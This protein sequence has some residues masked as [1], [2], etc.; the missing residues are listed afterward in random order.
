MATTKVI[1]DL[2]DLNQTG[3]TTALK[4]CVGTNA[5]QPAT[6][7]ISVQ[8]LVVGGGGGANGSGSGG[9]GAGG[10]S[11]G[12]IAVPNNTAL[13]IVVGQG[14]LG[15]LN[16]ASDGLPA[17]QGQD[18]GFYTIQGQGGGAGVHRGNGLPGGS[19]AGA[20]VAATTVYS[21]GNSVSGQGNNGGSSSA[22]WSA[23]GGGGS[24]AVGTNGIS[25]Q[26]GAGGAGSN[27]VALGIITQANGIT[28]SIGEV[29]GATLNFAGGGGGGGSDAVA[30]GNT[31]GGSG[32]LGGGGNGSGQCTN[33]PGGDA[34]LNTGGGGGGSAAATVDSAGGS[35]GSGVVILKYAN[36]VTETIAG[37]LVGGTTTSTIGVCNYPTTAT[38]LYQFENTPNATC[39]PNP[40]NGVSGAITQNLTYVAGVP[41]LGASEKAVDFNGTNSYWMSNT[42]IIDAQQNMSISLWVKFDVFIDTGYLWTSY[43]TGDMVLYAGADGII[44]GNVWNGGSQNVSSSA[45]ST[46]TWY[47]VVFTRSTSNGMVLYING[48]S[49]STNSNTTNPAVHG[50]PNYDTIGMYGHR[51]LNN[52]YRAEF[53]GQIDQ[54]RAFQSELTSSQVLMLYGEDT[55]ATKFTE[56]S[57]TVLVFKS[58]SGTINLTDTSLP[59]PKVGDLRTNTDQ[60]SNSSASA[61]EH[62]M[63]TGWRVFNN[64]SNSTAAICNYPTTALALYQFNDDVTDTCNNY[65]GT[66]Y[67]LNAYVGGKI[68]KA[69]SFNGSSSKVNITSPIG[70]ALSNANDDFSVSLWVNW[71]SITGTAGGFNGAIIGNSSANNYGS[72][73][74]Y[75]Y[76]NAAGISISVERYFN[77]TGYYS[78]GYLT[79]APFSGVINTWYNLV[80]TYVGSSKT[81]TT[82]V[83]G[84]ALPTYTLNT[85]AGSRTMSSLNSFGSYNGS[86]SGL[87]GYLDQLR[88]FPSVLTAA[89]VTQL[90]NES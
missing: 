83:N 37:S 36:T 13:N 48:A 79:A 20:G 55:G 50:T 16:N 1:N 28:A 68:G 81:V 42:S 74:I 30:G 56:G 3:N 89:Q 87:D 52:G 33:C 43:I 85:N 8:Y 47:H 63:S 21:G 57:N 54:F 61:M 39:G 18:S 34:T 67:N 11:N 26:A 14:G 12:T 58:G 51:P 46:S 69:A 10:L 64:V 84:T 5:Q 15:V 6:P 41:Q 45:L 59:G 70:N 38:A 7:T 40:S 49:V 86:Y 44:R 65:N 2:I 76:G 24:G 60:T 29:N 80:L 82:Y 66:A 62:F 32:G 53:N 77:N 78:S 73:A 35:G 22:T 71:N 9:G 19:G 4:G 23:G 17:N 88:I 31:I 25:S 27:A 75:S 72:F 90:Y